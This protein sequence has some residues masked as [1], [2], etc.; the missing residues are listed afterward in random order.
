MRRNRRDRRAAIR[1]S[2]NDDRDD[3]DGSENT[4]SE[5]DVG[6]LP[7]HGLRPDSDP[8]DGDPDPEP[9]AK[10]QRVSDNET[11]CGVPS[12]SSG[13]IPPLINV[14]AATPC[15]AAG[16]LSLVSHPLYQ[17]GAGGNDNRADQTYEEDTNDQQAEDSNRDHT[18]ASRRDGSSFQ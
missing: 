4:A 14:A 2:P 3:V 15:A 7:L 13:S 16:P 5:T 10:R 17:R 12:S 8:I 11:L 18:S 9:D 1:R 6:N